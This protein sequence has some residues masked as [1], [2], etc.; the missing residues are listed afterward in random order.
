MEQFTVS[1][2]SQMPLKPGSFNRFWLPISHLAFNQSAEIKFVWKNV[3]SCLISLEPARSN[4]KL[5]NK[6]QFTS[7]V[8]QYNLNSEQ[9]KTNNPSAM[10]DSISRTGAMLDTASQKISVPLLSI[11]ASVTTTPGNSLNY[12]CKL[13][14]TNLSTQQTTILIDQQSMFAPAAVL[15]L[16]SWNSNRTLL[17]I[18]PNL[19]MAGEKK[20]KKFDWFKHETP[21][22]CSF[23]GQENSQ[24]DLITNFPSGYEQLTVPSLM[25]TSWRPEE[26]V[27]EISI[28]I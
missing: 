21:K 20:I 28:S 11:K 15:L 2:L 22:I 10:V 13:I 19:Y 9:L 12:G 14:L 8:T 23:I 1:S 18:Q 3:S 27:E 6:S 5:D 16:M 24:I 26:H 25:P 7:Y 4:A 17:Q